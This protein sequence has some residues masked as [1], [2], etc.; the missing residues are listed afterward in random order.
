MSILT[1]IIGGP[2]L[3]ALLLCAVPRNYK[4]IMRLVAVV[5]AFI[6]MILAIVMFWRFNQAPGDADGYKF[7]QEISWWGVQ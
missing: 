7:V 4:L 3:A 1:Y 5:A 6:S 2:F